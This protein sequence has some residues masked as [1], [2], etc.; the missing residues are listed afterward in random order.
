[1]ALFGT[2]GVRRKRDSLDASAAFDLS[3]AF[4][5]WCIGAPPPNTEVRSVYCLLAEQ[6]ATIPV[7]SQNDFFIKSGVSTGFLFI[8]R[9]AILVGRHNSFR[10]DIIKPLTIIK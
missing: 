7:F 5:A 3:A 10:N 1:M 8:Y 6:F 2:N 9:E 4:A